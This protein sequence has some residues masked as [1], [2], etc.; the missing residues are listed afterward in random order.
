VAQ[1]RKYTPE[2]KAEAVELVVSSGRPAA[3]I[4]RELGIILSSRVDH[5]CELGDCF[6]DGVCDVAG[7][8]S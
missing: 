6:V 5:G 2:F 3:E 1:R 8:A 7:P 4:A